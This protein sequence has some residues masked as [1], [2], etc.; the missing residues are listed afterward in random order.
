VTRCKRGELA[1]LGPE[2]REVCEPVQRVCRDGVLAL[3][4]RVWPGLHRLEVRVVR[5]HVPRSALIL[6]PRRQPPLV[7]TTF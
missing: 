5:R 1:N 4:E 3:R 2:R 6:L 7:L